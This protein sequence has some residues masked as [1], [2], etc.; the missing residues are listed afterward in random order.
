MGHCDFQEGGATDTYDWK[1]TIG[2]GRTSFLFGMD[3]FLKICEIIGAEPVITIS[4]F[5]GNENDAADLIE[6]LNAPDDGTHPWATRRAENGH[7]SP[8]GVKY[9]EISNEPW[10]KVSAETY[11]Q[12][13]LLYYDALKSADST[14][15]VGVVLY[16]LAWTEVVS[17]IVK[18][19]ADFGILHFYP[20][21]VWG[22]ALETIPADEI[23]RV[24]LEQP[25]NIDEYLISQAQKNFRENS[26]KLLPM[27]I[28]EFNGGYVQ[29]IPV[30]Y[31][32]TLGCALVNAEL[33]H[34]FLKPENKIFLANYWQYLNTY[35]GMI[36]NGFIGYSNKLYN[37]Y[38]K[39]PNYYVFELYADHFGSTLIRTDVSGAWFSVDGGLVSKIGTIASS[40]LL[41][42]VWQVMPVTG[43]KATQAS[44]VL[45]LD[46]HNPV[47][48]DYYHSKQNANV[49][50]GAYYRISGYIKA[51]KLLDD[52]GFGIEVFDSRGI[53]ITPPVMTNKVYGT[54]DWIFV[55]ALYLAPPDAKGVRV[56]VRRIGLTGP[57][58]GRVSIRDVKLEKF[59][60]SYNTIKG[61]YLSV[62]A[63]KSADG[64]KMYLMVLNK[65]LN[66]SQTATITVN[67]FTPGSIGRAY[68]LNGSSI[69]STNEDNHYNVKITSETFDVPLSGTFDYTFE[70]HS[71]TAIEL[72]NR[73]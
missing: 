7:P 56:R 28:T 34:I 37:P 8:Y 13:Y 17:G 27:A 71:V 20:T 50:G 66:Y 36:S 73:F 49:E 32:H 62:N 18:G 11:A 5:I 10:T 39:R 55:Q 53:G 46:F 64:N 6:Y 47:S 29:D 44:G 40:N 3:E 67:G 12:R 33:L 59:V 58:D 48:F 63:S 52:K 72:E 26:G 2:K 38:Y 25:V 14:V 31:R 68:V 41:S 22:A 70:P 4:Y 43:V 35:T 1:K 24:S 23:F 60:P 16:T 15:Q 51:D 57:L 69:V 21:P 61:T 19:K 30:P 42:S 9:F 54:T 65:D 45:T